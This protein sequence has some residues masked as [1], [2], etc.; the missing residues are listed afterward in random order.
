MPDGLGYHTEHRAAIELEVA[1]FNRIQFH[2]VK[3]REKSAP[4]C[5]L[6][7]PFEKKN[8]V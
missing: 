1:G 2:E 6:N 4:R 8:S 3:I 5:L 7:F